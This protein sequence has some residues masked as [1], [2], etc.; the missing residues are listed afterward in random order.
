MSKLDSQSSA[1]LAPFR[2]DLRSL[3]LGR[4]FLGLVLLWDLTLSFFWRH[5]YYDELGVLPRAEFA[6]LTGLESTWSPYFLLSETGFTTFLLLL[7]IVCAGLFTIG[8][9]TRVV[10]PAMWFLMLSLHERNPWILIGGD[11]WLR[12]TLFWL[13]FLPCARYYSLDA[14]EQSED[15]ESPTTIASAAS[16][17]LVVQVVFIYL[18]AGIAKS[19]EGYRDGT[20]LYYLLSGSEFGQPRARWLLYFPSVL[21]TAS[22]MVPWLE[23]GSACCLIVPFAT[24]YSRRLGIVLLACLHGGIW[25]GMRLHHFTAVAFATLLMLWLP[26]AVERPWKGRLSKWLSVG[27]MLWTLALLIYN[28]VRVLGLTSL[29]KQDLIR[30]KML[31]LEQL[32]QLFAPTAPTS[33]FLVCPVAILDGGVEQP[34]GFWGDQRKEM[35]GPED[36]ECHV[37]LARYWRSLIEA[38]TPL[39]ASRRLGSYCRWYAAEWSRRYPGQATRLRAIRLYTR[40]YQVLPDYEDSPPGN[41]VLIEEWKLPPGSG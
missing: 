33:S 10:T 38:P 16:L 11:S 39:D 25:Y 34:L 29:S 9:R 22:Q 14:R 21:R 19:G 4:V 36:P 40:T 23:V 26:T 5:R 41:P 35:P 32:W 3:A 13:I 24:S 28:P 17:G 15:E 20:S 7:T 30:A 18:W 37:R 27:L 1:W 31:G 12:A 6:G 2:L 8:W